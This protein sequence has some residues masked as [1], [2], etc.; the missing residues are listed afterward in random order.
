[1]TPFSFI[2]LET[3]IRISTNFP[4]CPPIKIASGASNADKSTDKKS[5]II[6]SIPGVPKRQQF[7]VINFRP[8]SRISKLV[9]CKCGNSNLASIETEPVQKPISQKRSRF[10]RSSM[11]KDNK[12]IGILVIIFSRP[13][14]CSNAESG[15]PN[16]RECPSRSFFR[17]KQF[18]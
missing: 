13:F 11:L 9:I 18:G 10:L 3:T 8:S 6:A 15:R 5:P 12:R 1:M 4:P 2:F 17:I 14:K 16:L 7:S